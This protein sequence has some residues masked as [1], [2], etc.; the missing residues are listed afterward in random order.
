MNLSETEAEAP[1]LTLGH[2][3]GKAPGGPVQR[4]SDL[5]WGTVGWGP[6]GLTNGLG[7]FLHDQEMVL[8]SVLALSSP[9]SSMDRVRDG[10]GVQQTPAYAT[11]VREATVGPWSMSQIYHHGL[12]PQS[13]QPRAHLQY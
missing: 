7:L 9:P 11:E 6:G 8:A 13:I 3:P 1:Q 10:L 12:D 5:A 2:S 4:S